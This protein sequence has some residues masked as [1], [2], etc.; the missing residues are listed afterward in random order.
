MKNQLTLSYPPGTAKAND[1]SHRTDIIF[2][3]LDTVHLA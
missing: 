2:F 3:A 1:V